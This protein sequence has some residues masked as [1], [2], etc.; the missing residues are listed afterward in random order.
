MSVAH[1]GPATWKGKAFDP[2]RNKTY[3]FSMAVRETTM[4]TTGCI[5][6]VLCKD[7]GWTRLE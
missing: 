3:G 5:L 7:M 6:G 2:Q 4:T 1:T